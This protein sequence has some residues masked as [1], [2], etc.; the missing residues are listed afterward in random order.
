M[1]RVE[2][3]WYELDFDPVHVD[4]VQEQLQRKLGW[5]VRAIGRERTMRQTPSG[6]WL[7]VPYARLAGY[8]PQSVVDQIIATY[9]PQVLKELGRPNVI[10]CFVVPQCVYL[11]AEQELID[12]RRYRG[13]AHGYRLLNHPVVEAVFRH[14]GLMVMPAT[15]TRH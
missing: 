5:L 2:P 14:A 1:D 11:A 4:P 9:E 13:K 8:C 12:V 10:N 6:E 15:R 3:R 7:Q